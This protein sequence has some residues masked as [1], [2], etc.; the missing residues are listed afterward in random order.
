MTA[1]ADPA[2]RTRLASRRS[3]PASTPTSTP[4]PAADPARAKR[5][6]TPT[7][8]LVGLVLAALSSL[9][10]PLIPDIAEAS[11]VTLS[12]G[13]WLLTITLLTGALST[14]ILGRLADGPRQRRVIVAA[15]V[16]TLIGCV[17]AALTSS[18]ALLVVARGLQGLGLGLLPVTMAI[19]RRHLP[20]AESASTIAMLSVT[21]AIGVGLGYPITGLLAEVSDYH[22][23]F[24]FGAIVVAAALLF[25]VLV[26]P[27]RSQAPTRPFDAVGAALLTGAVALFILVLSEGESWGWGSGLVIGMFA[28]SVV[29]LAAWARYELRCTDPLIDLRQARNRMVLTADLSGLIISLTMYLFLP[30]VVEFVQV[31]SSVGFGFGASVVIA[32]CVLIP[33][34]VGT[35]VA[36]RIAPVYERRFGRRTM[37]PIGS[38]LF[39]VA[40]A[41]FAFEHSSLWEAFL[42]MAIAGIGIGFT[43]A[44]MPGF[45]VQAVAAHETG[46]AMGFYQVLRSVGLAIGSAVSGV[47]LAMYTKPHS[48]FPEVGGFRAAL[49]IGAILCAAVAVGSYI[50]PGRA[51]SQVD[52]PR[53]MEE[54][55][56]LGG[57]ALMLTDDPAAPASAS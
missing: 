4:T 50:L 38:V 34:S 36:S 18:F 2:H 25:S 16:P 47:A 9:G 7:L 33:L 48:A 19:A 35:F 42:V 46:S 27:A 20:P 56:E 21:A 55:A 39:A 12:T 22:L 13:A 23:A 51:K 32:G 5:G 40:M 52:D 53:E 24:W 30:I 41:L 6:L 57:A 17:L 54:N 45:I 15:L 37:I 11:H 28:L 29:L 26:I 43:F 31:P 3:V 14:P 49:I 10:A 44:A 8:I 1:T